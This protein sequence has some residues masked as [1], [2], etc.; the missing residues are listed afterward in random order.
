[1]DR[2]AN[3]RSSSVS[4]S[5]RLPP[6][7]KPPVP[8]TAQSRTIAASCGSGVPAPSKD[9]SCSLQPV[10]REKRGPSREESV[11]VPKSAS[12]SE[13]VQEKRTNCTSGSGARSVLIDPVHMYVGL[14]CSFGVSGPSKNY[15]PCLKDRRKH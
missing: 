14:K 3:L 1:M 11:E 6:R 5:P 2:I 10:L 12:I 9:Y 7:E 8:A 4:G 15:L 13:N